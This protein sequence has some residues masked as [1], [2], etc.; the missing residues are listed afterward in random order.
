LSGNGIPPNPM[1]NLDFPY[2]MAILGFVGGFLSHGGSP[3]I[4]VMDG[5]D[6]LLKKMLLIGDVRSY[7]T[8]VY[9]GSRTNPYWGELSTK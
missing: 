3:F 1:V 8:L 4:Q 5:H 2:S 9:W 6:L 7:T